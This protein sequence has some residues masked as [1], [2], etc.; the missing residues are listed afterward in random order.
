[1]T[2]VQHAAE[3]VL[4]DSSCWWAVSLGLE[5]LMLI[6]AKDQ[7]LYAFLSLL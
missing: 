1:V 7:Q 2:H 4:L 6:A 5:T 3:F